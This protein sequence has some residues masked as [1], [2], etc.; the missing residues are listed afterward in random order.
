MAMSG[1]QRLVRGRAVTVLAEHDDMA[2]VQYRDGQKEV[3]EYDDLDWPDHTGMDDS[4]AFTALLERTDWY[5]GLDSKAGQF[6]TQAL[7]ADWYASDR[8]ATLWDMARD[9]VPVTEQALAA[10]RKGTDT[11]DH[12]RSDNL[13]FK[14][15]Q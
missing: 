4:L 5:G 3:V 10:L 11:A 15:E 2:V 13:F 7:L 12:T 14:E 1:V 6:E 9:R 8:S